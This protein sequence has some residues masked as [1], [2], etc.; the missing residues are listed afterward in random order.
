LCA[1]IFTKQT[2]NVKQKLSAIKMM[3]KEKRA[4]G[5]IRATR[6]HNNIRNVMQNTKIA[7]H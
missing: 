4:D 2:E 5:K 7:A 3:A 6:D 1:Y